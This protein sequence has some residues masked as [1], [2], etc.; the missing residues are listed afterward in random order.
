MSCVFGTLDPVLGSVLPSL[1]I[2]DP[3]LGSVLPS[4][5]YDAPALIPTSGNGLG[6]RLDSKGMDLFVRFSEYNFPDGKL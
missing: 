2:L 4:L 3:I 6:L 5:T 1:T